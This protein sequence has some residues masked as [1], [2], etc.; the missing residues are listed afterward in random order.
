MTSRRWLVVAAVVAL[1][2]L[3]TTAW[4]LDGAW[5]ARRDALA[6]RNA[7]P[8]RARRPARHAHEPAQPAAPGTRRPGPGR[9]GARRAPPSWSSSATTSSP[10]RRSAATTPRTRATRRTPRWWWY[11]SASVAPTRRST[12]SSATTPRRRSRRCSSSTR[13]AVRPRPRRVGRRRST[14][15]TSRTRTC[16]SPGPTA[17]PSPRT[18]AA[19][20][21]RSCTGNPTARGPRRGRRSAGSR[22]G[23]PGAGRGRRR[24][25]HVSAGS[26]CTTRCANRRPGASACPARRRSRPAARTSTR[27]PRR[28]RAAHARRSTPRPPSRPTARPV[29]LWKRERPAAIVA[30]PL[31]PDGLA[32]AGTE[33]ELLRANQRW[34]DTNVEAPSM[35]VTGGGAWLFF[36]GGNWNGGRYATG[37]VH[38]AS[39][40]GPCDRSAAGA[41]AVL[42]R[43]HRRAR[44][45]VGV[46]GRR[47]GRSGSRTTR[48]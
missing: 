44:R 42:A 5:D 30:Q 47:R 29:L 46:P 32:L 9:H 11:G 36:S 3:G 25:S 1:V 39:A 14:A 12:R 10:P 45:C 13:R 6:A 17:T 4:N 7:D 23:P 8:P 34:E 33:R 31:T 41:A 18:R 26:S 15:S 21:S 22:T 24:C 38:C 2:A 48:T 28:S 43:P 19:A 16:S 20:T 35:L 40:L 37:V 27:R